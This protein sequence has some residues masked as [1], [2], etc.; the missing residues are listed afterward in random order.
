MRVLQVMAGAKY[1]GAESFFM[2][3]VVALRRAGLHQRVVIRKNEHR[4]EIFREGGIEPVELRFGGRLDILTRLGIKREI[5]SFHP[6]IVITW[7]NRASIVCP[8]GDF[9]RVARL[10]GYYEVL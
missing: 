4:A 1:G 6:H 10:G 5:E 7:M 8:K 3:L 2:R 9:V